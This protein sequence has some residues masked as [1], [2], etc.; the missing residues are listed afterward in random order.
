MGKDSIQLTMW[1]PM[2]RRREVQLGT[3]VRKH[4]RAFQSSHRWVCIGIL[5]TWKRVGK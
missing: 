4:T 1:A 2:I 5:K 3:T